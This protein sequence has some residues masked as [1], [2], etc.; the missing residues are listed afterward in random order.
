MQ[1]SDFIIF[2][3][4]LPDDGSIVSFRNAFCYSCVSLTSLKLQAPRV[5]SAVEQAMKT[6]A[7]GLEI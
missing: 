2:F 3:L 6:R 4:V 7:G 1:Q 5:R